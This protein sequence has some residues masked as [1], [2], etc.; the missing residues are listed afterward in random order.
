MTE[1]TGWRLFSLGTGGT[2]LPPFVHRQLPEHYD[3]RRDAWKPGENVAR[4][5]FDEHA[6]PSEDCRCGLRVVLDR[7]EL[8]ANTAADFFAGETRTILDVTG[9]MAEVRAGGRSL[10]G[11]DMP[12]DDPLS[13]V[14]VERAELVRLYLGPGLAPHGPAVERRYGVPALLAPEWWPPPAG[15]V[16]PAL[17]PGR[18]A[19]LVALREQGLGDADLDGLNAEAFLPVAEQFAAALRSG[20][21][22]EDCFRAV[23]DSERRPTVKQAEGFVLLVL[24][25]FC[26]EVFPA[27]GFQATAPLTG[28]EVL[29]RMAR[30]WR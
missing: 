19:F 22:A 23:F 8:L 21:T 17:P 2:L 30:A 16:V 1:L 18:E 13:T 27:R 20:V 15:P 7:A 28:R 24:R 5:V 26:P 10:P 29:Q 12:L 6:A 9:V 25:N 3:E 4:C 14:R 11:T